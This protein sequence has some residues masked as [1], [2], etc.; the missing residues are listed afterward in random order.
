MLENS[1]ES[2]SKV[3]P[4]FIQKSFNFYIYN[5]T[6]ENEHFPQKNNLLMTK[7]GRKSSKANEIDYKIH[8]KDS[9]DNIRRKIKTHFHNFMIALL[10]M[11]IRPYLPEDERFGKISFKITQDLTIE[12]N[13]KLFETKIKDIIIAM[14]NKYSNKNRNKYILSQIMKIVPK[15]SELISLLNLNY[16]D[17]YLDH[18][19]KSNKDIFEGEEEDESYEAHLEKLN[20]KFGNKYTNDFKNIAESLIDFFYNCKKREKKM[21]LRVP[22]FVNLYDSV[23]NYKNKSFELSNIPKIH[24]IFND[25]ETQTDNLFTD[26]EDPCS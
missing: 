8:G 4:S 15:N 18:Y 21:K 5:E 20:E 7:R 2:E 10:N 13:Q 17:L 23:I 12:Y 22:S 24:K 3:T 19:L 6:N 16:K 26:D 1:P 14:S 25:K 9:P 11:K